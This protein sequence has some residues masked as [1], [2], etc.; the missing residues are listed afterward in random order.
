MCK[1]YTNI[2]YHPFY[3]K[4]L[5]VGRNDELYSGRSGWKDLLG[6]VQLMYPSLLLGF[7]PYATPGLH[8]FNGT[9]CLLTFWQLV[10]C[11]CR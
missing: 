6:A 9:S 11:R 4:L 5:I 3:C 8:G 10:V 2:D 7:Y 1:C